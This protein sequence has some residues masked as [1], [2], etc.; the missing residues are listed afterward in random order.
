[1][2]KICIDFHGVLTNGKINISSDGHTQY[3]AVHVK[4]VAAIR[5]LIALGFEVYIVTA[6]TSPIIDAYC[7]KV[8]CIKI[9]SRV[10]QNLFEKDSYIAIGDSAFDFQ[11]LL[12]SKLAFCPADA[13]TLVL[14][15]KDIIPLKTKGGDGCIAEMLEILKTYE[16]A[17]YHTVA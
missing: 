17:G 3:E 10:K 2:H 15:N 9:T 6:S 8:G 12:D 5:E 14:Q 13:E 16:I 11:F 4:D 7:K 1:M